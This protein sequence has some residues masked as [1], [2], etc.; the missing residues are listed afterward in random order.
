MK[1]DEGNDYLEG[2]TGNDTLEGGAGNDTIVQGSGV[3]IID[4]GEG[5]DTLVDADFSSLNVNLTFDDSGNTYP[6]TTL[7]NG[8]TIRNVEYFDNPTTGA[9]NDRISF[10]RLVY[11]II[12]TGEGNDEINPGFGIDTVNAGGGDDLLIADYSTASSPVGG[13]VMRNAGTLVANSIGGFNGTFQLLD[14]FSS[15]IS[16][17]VFS[18]VERFQVLGTSGSDAL[19]TGSGNDTINGN[20]GDDV[21]VGGGGD[22]VLNG[23]TGNDALYGLEGNDSIKG[24]EGNDYL[25]GGTGN[26]TLEGGGGIDTINPGGGADKIILADAIKQYYDDLNTTTAGINDY[27]NILGFEAQDI[28][29]LAGSPS[30]YRL[31]VVGGNTELYLDKPSSEPDEL[32][33]LFQGVTNLSLTSDNFIYVQPV[34]LSV[35][36]AT[37]TEAGATVIT[38]TATTL[39]PVLRNQSVD[40]T[41]SGTITSADYTLSSNTIIIPDGSNTGTV[42]FTVVNDTLIEPTETATL[43]LTNPSSSLVLGSTTSQNITIINDDF[44]FVNLSVNSNAGSEAGT[45]VI[46]VTATASSPVLSAQTVNLAV[47]GTGITPGDYT[48]SNSVINIPSGGTTG[49][50]TFTIVNDILVEGTENATIAISSISSGLLLGSTTAQTVTIADNDFP[51]VNLSVS[52]NIGSEAGTTVITVTALTTDPVIG[53][54]TVDLAIT[55]TGITSGDYNLSNS[56]V[57]ILNGQTTGTV[58]FTVIDD[59]LIEPTEA[60]TL[61]LTN[62]SSGLILGSTISQ[63]ITLTNNDFPVVSLS[64]SSNIGSEAGTTVITVTATTSDP[65][66]GNQTIDL[67]IT[68]TGI[69]SGDY[70]LS[71]STITIVDGQTTGTVTFTVVDDAL[72]EATEIATLT[73]TNPSSG[74]ILGN[75]ILQ[76]IT[77]T[78]N[79]FAPPEDGN[80]DGIPDDQQDNVLSIQVDNNEYVTFAAPLGQPSVNIQTTPNPDPANTPP[81]VDFSL[82]FFEFNFPQVTPGEATTI[83]LFLPQGSLAN[84]YWKYGATPDNSNPHWYNFSFDSLT[85]TG[86][87]FQDLNGDGQNEII[88][89]FVDGQR[90]DDDLMANGQISDPG[91]PAF[92]TNTPATAT[93]DTAT[94]DEDTPIIISVLANDSIPVGNPLSL[95]LGTLPSQGI[96]TL[97][98]NGTADNPNDDTFIYTPNTNFNGTDTFTYT[99]GNGVETAIATVTITVNPVNDTPILQNPIA[100]RSTVEGQPFTLTLTANVFGDVDGDNLTYSLA[101]VTLPDGITFTP[102]TATFS[103][104]PT[105][106]GSFSLTVIASDRAGATVEDTF[107]LDILKPMTVA[108]NGGTIAGSAGNDLIDASGKTGTY[109]LESGTGN[110][111]LIGSAQRDVLRGG[112]GNDSLYGGGDIDRLFGDEGDDLLDGGLGGDFLT[113]GGGG[114]RFVLVLGNGGD[115]ILDFNP[116][117]GDRFALAGVDFGQLDFNSNRIL[118]GNEVLAHVTDFQ[119]NPLTTLNRSEWFIAL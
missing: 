58:T 5:L 61:T 56:T 17:I 8:T 52:S 27:A 2:G 4:G 67:A 25:E 100:D 69:T 26:D 88:L 20:Q 107:T 36:T 111:R 84:S 30:L 51:R 109:R 115:R 63:A 11:N 66:I 43:T 45:T 24:D 72:V 40:L 98:D 77:L 79:D 113:G 18:S 85:N 22:D 9:G 47:T 50:R 94:T 75:T 3:N 23:G 53:N 38:L 60:A 97:N 81:N 7:A 57:T 32:I 64:L 70:N 48:L 95:G 99:L 86:A 42:T 119:G 33:G 14:R 59:T 96:A 29:Q 103:G 112:T 37:G 49:T 62:P 108:N 90:G 118:F 65:V 73:L 83:T 16:Q 31:N 46:T 41:V 82:G 12:N 68:G 91:A 55:G 34:N 10:N 78:D 114:D 117:E 74:L 104:I 19:T 28:I 44:P 106:S 71:N 21:I 6:T 80:F 105:V 13:V 87:T 76:N 39:S 15:V 101:N 93:N 116:T 110:D 54:Q 102:N 35:S 92:T 1:G 89:Y